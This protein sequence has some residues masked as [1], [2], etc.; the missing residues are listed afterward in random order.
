MGISTTYYDF[1]VGRLK[2]GSDDGSISFSSGIDRTGMEYGLYISDEFEIIKNLKA[3]AGLRLSGWTSNNYFDGG[4]EPRLAL[5]Y[6]VNPRW[7]IKGGYARMKQY[8]HLI[9]NSGISLPTDVWYPSTNAVHPQRSDQVSAGF[10]YLIAKGLL[11]TNEYYYKWLKNQVDFYIIP[12]I[13]KSILPYFLHVLHLAAHILYQ[14]S[15]NL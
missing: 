12:V 9:S 8:V 3:N 4:I 6:E 7:S 5:L 2:A 10:S 14:L 15:Q 13:L 11:L 1:T